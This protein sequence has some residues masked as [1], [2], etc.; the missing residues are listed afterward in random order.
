MSTTTGEGDCFCFLL[1]IILC[2]ARRT[3]FLGRLVGGTILKPASGTLPPSW[4]VVFKASWPRLSLLLELKPMSFVKDSPSPSPL[5]RNAWVSLL[6]SRI[7]IS[8]DHTLVNVL[9]KTNK[10]PLQRSL[11][12]FNDFVVACLIGADYIIIHIYYKFSP[13]NWLTVEPMTDCSNYEY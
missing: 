11:K 7:F 12:V 10:G 3:T 8:F 2:R 1:F 4:P 6:V 13:T 5:T 9:W